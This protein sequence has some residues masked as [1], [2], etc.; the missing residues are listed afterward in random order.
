MMVMIIV[1][2]VMVIHVLL[3]FP[4]LWI[5]H[6]KIIYFNL[7]LNV[8]IFSNDRDIQTDNILN[9][10]WLLLFCLFSLRLL[11]IL[12]A[13]TIETDGKKPTIK[14]SAS[15]NFQIAWHYALQSIYY[16]WGQLSLFSS[17]HISVKGLSPW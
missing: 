4:W 2:I 9:F 12:R 13:R 10:R 15:E 11:W 8:L 5:C 16:L 3:N 7:C 6:W 14:L 1:M 17:F